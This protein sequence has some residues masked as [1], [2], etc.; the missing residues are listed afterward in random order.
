[1]EYIIFDLEAT[2]WENTHTKISE[3]I[4]I[5]S[6][7]LN[8]NLEVID[9][10]SIFV[11]PYIN[12]IL[13]SFCTDL[14]TI[15]QDNVNSAPNFAEAMCKFETFITSTSEHIKLISWG[16]YDKNQIIEESL[17]KK[18]SGPILRLLNTH[19]NL[20]NKFSKSYNFKRA[21]MA[22][23]L[24]YLNIKLEGTHHRGIDDA[25][26]ISLIFQKIYNNI[27]L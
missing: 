4:E 23:A 18:Y 10:F 14:T 24:K 27:D 20:K 1:M 11:K 25:K 8:N 19:I 22:S 2:C 17:I 26:N 21:G 3:I 15:S 6:V 9:T 7:K 12:P 5:G 13:S 16:N